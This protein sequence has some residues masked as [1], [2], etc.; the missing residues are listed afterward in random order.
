[1]QKDWTKPKNGT[2]ENTAAILNSFHNDFKLVKELVYD[3]CGF[4]L[5]NPIKNSESVA[6]GAGSFLLNGKAIEFRVAKITPKKDGL[7]VAI[8]KRNEVGQTTPFALSDALDC[9]IIT[10]R[11]Q[12]HFGKFVFPKIILAEKGII[13]QNKKEG[14]RGIRVYPPWERATNKQ[15]EKTQKWQS[16][17]F[18]PLT[19]ESSI[20]LSLMKTLLQ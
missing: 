10:V 13:T 20:D 5:E 17:Y 3:K 4:E 19:T 12:N 16:Q 15:A 14:K 18:L 9:I 11:K 2:S 1:V 8:W 7:F 6:Y